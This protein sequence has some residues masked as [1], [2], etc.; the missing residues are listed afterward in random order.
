MAQQ[1]V[2]NSSEAPRVFLPLEKRRGLAIGLLLLMTFYAAL[3]T[4]PPLPTAVGA[5]LDPSWMLGLNLAHAR[6]F[7][8]GP[9][10]IFTY[11]PLGYVIWP[12]ATS[13]A[14]S[15]VLAYHMGLYLVWIFALF[16][17]ALLGISS[18]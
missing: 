9:D 15:A 7:A 10:F 5:G 1:L 13:G 3:I 6:N 11:G 2:F 17:I 16:C 12:D 18:A 14:P 4:V 8:P